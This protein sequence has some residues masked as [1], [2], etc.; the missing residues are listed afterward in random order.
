MSQSSD[1]D[2]SLNDKIEEGLSSF[3]DKTKE[4]TGNLVDQAKDAS[5]GFVDNIKSIIPNVT[6]NEES[7][8][9]NAP[10]NITNI[11]N[12]TNVNKEIT[13]LDNPT[14][15]I[16]AAGGEDEPELGE[17]KEEEEPNE[18]VVLE[19]GDVIYIVDPSS[20]ILNDNTFII[21]YI[22]LKKI[23]LVNIKSFEKTQ[24]N[25]NSN[26]IIGDGTIQEIKILSRNSDKGF[27]RQNGLIPGK[28]VNIYFGGE[29]PAVITGEITNLE[30]DMI[31]IKTIDDDTIYINFDYQGIPEN[32]PI[33]T[34]ELRPEPAYK[35]EI[36]VE[37]EPGIQ[38]EIELD[39]FAEEKEEEKGIEGKTI[40]KSAVREKVK[41]LIIEGDQ[42]ILGDAVKIQEYV[43]ID[44]DKYRFNIETQTNDLLEE[45]VSTIP[46]ARR[47]PNVL[48]NI[49]VMIT[50]F[51]ELRNQ[52]ST[53]DIN[54][55]ITG[56][57]KKTAD[58]R[59]L[60]DYLSKFQNTLYWILLVAKN[61]KKVY[62]ANQKN[63]SEDVNDIQNIDINKDIQELGTLFKNYRANVVS[64][65][66][67]KYT[68]LYNSIN[69]FMTPFLDAENDD[70]TQAP[71]VSSTITSNINAI[72]DN[73]GDLYSTIVANDSEATRKFVLQRYCLGLDKLDA[74]NLKGSKMIAH[75]VKLTPNDKIQIKSIL[76]LPEPTVR[77]SQINLP[78]SNLLVKSNLNLHFINYW[79]LLKQKTEVTNIDIN[80]LSD[81]IN[82][83][84]DNFV[85]NIKNYVLDFSENDRPE[86]LSDVDIYNEFLKIIIPKTRILFNLVKKYIKGKLSMVD[87]IN[88]LEP[89]LIYS[90]DLTYMQYIEFNK[91]IQSKIREYNTNF[92]EYSRAFAVIK[93]MNYN[94]TYTNPLFSLLN[95][96]PEINDIV[97][98]T[99]GLNDKTK[100]GKLTGS[101]FLK[102]IKLD[103]FGNI[104]NIGI[105]F[106]NLQLM[107]P[108]EL[109]KILEADKNSI[110]QQLEKNMS[111]DTCSSYI[112]AKKYYSL[113][114]LQID[115]GQIIY[116]DKDF[117]TT[118]Y[119]I[120]D[121]DYKKERDT[122]TAEELTLYLTEQ[123]QKKYKKT[124]D[125]AAYMA[126]TLVNRAKRVRDGH[127]A[128]L[129]KSE[130]ATNEPTG[131]EYY[132]RK[133][134]QWVLVPDINP[135]WFIQGEDL[136]CNL[137]TDCLFKTNKT[138]ETC[139]STEVS[140][141][142]LISNALKE[143]M[144]QF[145]KNY[146]ISKE[147]FDTKIRE[148][149]KY[150]EEIYNRIQDIKSRAFFKYNKQ[151]YE[152]GL[153]ISE[154]VN[155]Q[156]ISPYAK[157]RNIIMSQNDFVK[158]QNDIIQFVLKFCRK[159][160][161]N[162]PNIND[163]EME[164]E[165]WLYCKETNVKLLPLFR[166]SLAKVFVT[167]P[168][169]Y[170][171]VLNELIKEIGKIG[172]NGDAWTDVNSGEIICYID[173]D[174]E[175]GYKD[176][177]KI[178]SRDVLEEEAS[179]QSTSKTVSNATKVENKIK[180]SPEGQLV[181]NVINGLAANMG[182]NIDNSSSFIIKVVTE[183]MNDSKVIYKEAAYR[184]K[185]K[186][187]A[188]E[189]KK[190]PEYS[191]I[192]SSTLLFLT[193]GMFLIGVQTNIPSLKTRKTFPGCVRSFSG[194]PIEGEGDDS[195][196]NYLACVAFKMKSKVMPWDALARVKEE[197][198][199]DT[200]KMFT[201]RYLLPYAEV[202]QKIKEKV[203][204]L[205]T[206][207]EQDI[208]DEHDLS[209]WTTFLPPLQRFHIKGLQNVTDGFSEDLER[210]I[211]IGSHKQLEKLLVIESKIIAF[212][213]A[214]Q[215]EIQKIIEKKD[216]LLRSSTNP[217][218]DN[219][220]CNEKE[221]MN[222][223]TLEYFVKDNPNIGVYN[224]VVKELSAVL[225][226]IK[227]LTQSSIMLSTVDTKRIFPEIPE[228]YSEE[229]I[230]RAFIDLCR[231]QSS[232][233]IDEDLATIC[234]DK[235]DYLSKN[236]TLQEKIS[237][238][239]R[240]GRNFTKES[241]LKLFQIVSRNNIIRI[242]LVD[243][244][245]SYSDN[246]R[247]Q[248]LK[249]DNEDDNIVSR[250]FRQKL[251]TLLDTYDI[252]IQ[253]DTEEMRQMKNYLSHAN[254]LMRK[255]I[256]DFI[257]RKAKV[258]SGELRRITGF[259]KDLTAWDSDLKPRNKHNKISDDAMYNYINFY[260]TFISLL[261]N[262]I[263]TMILNQQ[264]QTIEAPSYWGLS[265]QHAMDLKNIV[266]T[267]YEPLKKFYGNKTIVNVLYEIQSK[268][269]NL[270]LLA[271]TTPALT[272][273][274]IDRNKEE[275]TGP[276]E[277]YSVFD[278]RTATL[279]FEYYTLQIFIEYINLTKDPTMVSRMLITPEN[280]TDTIYS[281][282]FLI[283]QQL[284]FSE[285]EQQF[286][287]GDVVKL[288]ETVA[289]LLVAYVTMMMNSKDTID[290]S[291]DT[292][293]DRVF[294]LK[295]T[296]KYTFTDRLQ[297]LT[298]EER[299][300]DNILKINKLGVWS[301]GLTKGIKEYDPE[302]YDQEKEMTEKIA[303]IEKN[304]RQ[305]NANVTDSN[306]DM[307]FEDALDELDTEEFVN[308]D[309]IM[310]GNINEDNYD[311]DPFGDEIDQDDYNDYN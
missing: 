16:N 179:S 47:T 111:E 311:G 251:E 28:W 153:S 190:I 195:G 82:Y 30:E 151:Q 188:K 124:Q 45:M 141:E 74:T 276:I 41:Q 205:L 13:T 42:F 228:N 131:L 207:P 6:D 64:E 237:K 286:I 7:P 186:K 165:W 240:D 110:K 128:I 76:T 270:V 4:V 213:L 62:P 123:M 155:A 79:Q 189:G 104:Y 92:V 221:N 126:D 169:N 23:K 68:E 242:S 279:L 102:K 255:D 36:E 253:E 192:Y 59:P 245:V 254:D 60:A 215:E 236:D 171:T 67:N 97:F 37:K 50:R 12:T 185:E 148:K 135:E 133:D 14:E 181:S 87:L 156:I 18:E 308:H 34:F 226:D 300:V 230:Y 137:Q 93:N 198:L 152:I 54:H 69:P 33:E 220:C 246:L 178:K 99:Y 139:Q 86:G 302:N 174:V 43:N 130:G 73:L 91:F 85:D 168:D 212:S 29:Y 166:Y 129:A 304:I 243:S 24:L 57:I 289:R 201:I 223:T 275:S 231:F 127:Y 3:I 263:P 274:Q 1:T 256:I 194:F 180:L 96:N 214:M 138:D 11:T 309:E 115:N 103:D 297:N 146:Q 265:Q 55:N 293:M 273:I 9:Y 100:L 114:R 39:E 71:I 164:N 260:K 227:I 70:I 267:Y 142:T 95:N 262:V 234:I 158:K 5:I 117:D 52:S 94:I 49:H 89:F 78:G 266:E 271:N 292:V 80:S 264:T 35:K 159:G 88:Y 216:L 272:N 244:D 225:Q 136:L 193:L 105:A 63:M 116:F 40:P 184:E 287:E 19:L 258:G 241:F 173:A 269:R 108:T 113:D 170:H 17:E 48:N 261:T 291:Y 283:E 218:M 140:R 209:K 298:D 235:P 208:P 307:F 259:L 134:N 31:E 163:G 160:D 84:N 250:G 162:V 282:D 2:K 38:E 10:T 112:I 203:E 229:T 177:F 238:L 233:P 21:E 145:D 157:L 8:G 285:T 284:R 149:A 280:E 125:I 200:I 121:V 72:I 25:I 61:I 15:D 118:N 65:G 290:M 295:E 202:E 119:D 132:I 306:I 109:N 75:R 120:I 175:E 191:A 150:Y 22:N 296:E 58:D 210:E 232:V 301:K 247:K 197:K 187:A 224:N 172:G 66:Q 98:T 147:D 154:Q 248:L 32:L 83:E 211:K 252:S 206:S 182:I 310:M 222:N 288:Q 299:A 305:K 257:K 199:A 183:L 81:T 101:E 204:Y 143:I 219:A 90:N 303:T 107:Y 77:F 249:M 27:A 281:S 122:L 20:E 217:F 176:G 106:T 278:K 53:F 51:I 46:N 239:K 161:N 167:D 196:I 268:C 277:T 294:K 56:I 26:G 44:K 144:D